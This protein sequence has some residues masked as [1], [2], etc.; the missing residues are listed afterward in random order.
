MTADGVMPSKIYLSI[1]LVH[2][3][4][5]AIISL[6]LCNLLKSIGWIKE[7]DLKL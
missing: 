6:L 5:P 1:A 3:I 2:I 4:L 7:G